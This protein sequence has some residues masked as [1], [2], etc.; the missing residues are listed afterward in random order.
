MRTIQFNLLLA[1]SLAAISATAHHAEIGRYDPNDQGTI[2][3]EITDVFWRNPHVR[4]LLSRTGEGGQEEEWEIEFGS[5]NTVVRLGVSRDLLAVGDR[6][7][8][9]GSM[10]RNGLTAMFATGIVLPDGREVALQAEP[11]RRYG[12]TENAQRE[13]DT[14][15][16]TLRADIF[17]VW[18]PVTFRNPLS[19][20]GGSGYPLT[21]ACGPFRPCGIRRRIRRCGVFRR[22]CRLPWPTRIPCPSKTGAGPSSCGW[23]NGTANG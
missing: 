13:A 4:L 2:E 19:M 9:H 1:V 5:V 23:R 18:V 14:A 11:D 7:A 22:G 20:D 6:V 17:R 12:I 21:E 10:G 3:G 8:V 16:A 15:D